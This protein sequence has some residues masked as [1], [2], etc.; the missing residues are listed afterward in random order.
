MEEEETP[1]VPLVERTEFESFIGIMIATNAVLMGFEVDLAQTGDVGWIVV[2][3]FFCILWI[4]EMVLKMKTLHWQYFLS[5]YNASWPKPSRRA[6]SLLDILSNRR[7]A[8]ELLDF[9]LVLLA[10]AEAWVIPFLSIDGVSGL[11]VIRI[12]RILRMLRLLRLIRLMKLFKNLWLIIV[13]FRESLSTLFWVLMLLTVVIYVFAIF[14]RYTLNCFG[15]FREWDDCAEYFGSMPAA[16]YTLFQVITLESWSQAAPVGMVFARPILKVQP[17]FFIVFLLFLFLTTFGILNI[18]VGVIVENTLNAAKQNQ[19]LQERRMQ[20]QLRQARGPDGSGT[21]ERSEFIDILSDPLVQQTLTRMEV[22]VEDP[23]MLFEILDPAGTDSLSFPSFAQGVL[24]VKGPPTQLDMKTM[25]LG[26]ANISR[27]VNKVE[28]YLDQHSAML[29]RNAAM[30]G[31]LMTKLGCH[32]QMPPSVS[33]PSHR[34]H[35][36]SRASCGTESAAAGPGHGLEQD[37]VQDTMEV[38][39]MGEDEDPGELPLEKT[40][41]NESLEILRESA[42]GFHKKPSMQS[43]NVPRLVVSQVEAAGPDEQ[44]TS[45][46]LQT[47]RAPA[48]EVLPVR[49]KFSSAAQERDPH[50]LAEPETSGELLGAPHRPLGPDVLS[51]IAPAGDVLEQI[52]SSR[53]ITGSVVSRCFI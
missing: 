53:I 3:N 31:I 11:G 30:L 24:R 48:P 10:V 38:E 32:D 26:V 15:A 45:E 52:G 19:E 39:S 14:L 34:S 35:R 4:S 5:A 51:G 36:G 44:E 23:G 21:L 8:A 27:R 18:I 1:T 16:M 28:Q 12:V 6:E 47:C 49:P 9:G 7:M 42:A 22:P 2:E 33:Q 20:R 41:S 17:A 29:E 13:G 43:I 46:R 50:R 37:T 40:F 25:Q